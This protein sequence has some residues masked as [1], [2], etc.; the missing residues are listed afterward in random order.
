MDLADRLRKAQ[1]LV[2]TT[3]EK[4]HKDAHDITLTVAK[5]LVSKIESCAQNGILHLT[6]NCEVTNDALLSYTKLLE[7][8]TVEAAIQAFKEEIRDHLEGVGNIQIDKGLLDGII[9]TLTLENA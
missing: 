8:F 9:V 1:E 2:A 3:R 6:A 7:F 5:I 4:N